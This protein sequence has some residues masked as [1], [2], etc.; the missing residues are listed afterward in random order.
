MP[1]ITIKRG[2]TFR[3][4]GAVLTDVGA[5]VPTTGWQI[6]AQVRTPARA[7]VATLTIADRNDAAGT[8][9][10][11]SP[12]ADWPVTQLMMDVQYT[13][14]AGLISSTEDV[15]IDVRQDRTL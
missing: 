4:P 11:T 1:T 13:D 14:A 8:Y 15:L 12:T 10:L 2:D 6:A 5:A 9:T 7:H 3:K